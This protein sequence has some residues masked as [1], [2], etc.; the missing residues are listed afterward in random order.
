MLTE[1]SG[2]AS[3]TG[4]PSLATTSAH[5]S[6]V[7]A[8]MSG[9]WPTVTS[10]IV[11]PSGS[12]NRTVPGAWVPD[13]SATAT[14]S[15]WIATEVGD[16]MACVATFRGVDGSE[17]SST[18]MPAAPFTTHRRLV[19]AWNAAISLA[20]RSKTPV[21][22]VPSRCRWMPSDVGG[23]A[24]SARTIEAAWTIAVW[25][26]RRPCAGRRHATGPDSRR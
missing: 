17:M 1:P 18:S 13:G 12:R 16:G 26:S 2:S 24:A 23:S 8:H 19:G 11:R 7:N 22:C 25:W 9:P 5:P 4:S 10:A 14:R 6:G 20:L 21:A 3:P 15:P